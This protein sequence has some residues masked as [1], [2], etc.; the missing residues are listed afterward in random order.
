MNI[1]REKIAENVYFCGVTDKRYK[2]NQI[3]INFITNL[4]LDTASANALAAYLLDKS[5]SQYS[6][7]DEFAKYLNSLYKA[8]IYSSITSYGNAQ[9]I[10]FSANAIDNKYAL[11][12]EDLRLL[13]A[14]TLMNCVFSPATLDG[15]FYEERFKTER[16]NLVDD[17]NAVINEKRTFAIN[18]ANEIMF[19]G[20]PCGIAKNGT[21]EIAVNLENTEVFEVYKKLIST[22]KIEIIFIG[23]GEFDDIKSFVS[24]EI[25]AFSGERNTEI[26]P[27][28][29]SENEE[30]KEVTEY[31]NVVQSK[32]VLG[33]K[34]DCYSEA[35]M[36]VMAAL[37]GGTANSKLFK[38][39]R[40]KLSLCYYCAARATKATQSL[41]VD[42]GV[43]SE[44]IE[45][46]KAEILHQ[47]DLIKSGDVTDD[48]VTETKLALSGALK[49]T[50]DSPQALSAWFLTRILS[51]DL[52][53]PDEQIE[54]INAVTKDEII[55]AA[56][57]L[58]LDTVY[59]LTTE[60]ANE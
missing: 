45:K 16:K 39:V 13:S 9:I 26:L 1:K 18:R 24:S 5:N 11:S 48:E 25:S 54:K 29:T 7:Y 6:E 28:K 58:K 49:S 42:C 46:A 44:N 32:M 20:Q 60:G 2:T 30:T 23:C 17:I 57:S 55:S 10:S 38:N 59:V 34:S 33:F 4:S 12:G 14:K 52:I 22:A 8:E 51:G 47:L 53:T 41:K 36:S 19:S 27:L 37:Y 56:K 50:T 3:S 43:E 35:A 21:A 40:E 15:K 31:F